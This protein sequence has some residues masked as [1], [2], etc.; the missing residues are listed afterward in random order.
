MIDEQKEKEKHGGGRGF[1]MFSTENEDISPAV[2]ENRL[3]FKR[4][5]KS[6]TV[7]F[8]PVPLPNMMH[9]EN[10]TSKAKG[11]IK[12]VISKTRI[13][14]SLKGAVKVSSLNKLGKNV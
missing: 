5:K 9:H 2:V 14:N 1:G 12:E 11:L 7:S 13:I 10:K 3:N 6:G 8:L 4:P